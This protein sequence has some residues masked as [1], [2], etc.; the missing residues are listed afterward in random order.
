MKKLYLM[1]ADGKSGQGVRYCLFL[2]DST[3]EELKK[4]A[5]GHYVK[6]FEY[7]SEILLGNNENDLRIYR[8][9]ENE[10]QVI[11]VHSKNVELIQGI[12]CYER[13]GRWYGWVNNQGIELGEKFEQPLSFWVSAKLGMTAL[14]YFILSKNKNAYILSF[15]MK[16]ILVQGRYIGK[17][18]ICDDYIFACREDG[19][20]DVYNAGVLH[21][22]NPDMHSVLRPYL[23]DKNNRIYFWDEDKTWWCRLAGDNCFVIAD[24]ALGAHCFNP[25][26]N[27]SYYIL[28]KVEGGAKTEI[29]R[30]KYE[31]SSDCLSFEIGGL[32]YSMNYDTRL[33]DFDNP[34]PTFKLKIKNLFKLLW[35][36]KK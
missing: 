27:R 10:L 3:L 12:I 8:I 7:S 31:L 17:H 25:K 2:W 11:P 35:R 29:R 30:G 36:F 15:A 23:K 13:E 28:Y 9:Y 1:T 18:C 20:F 26:T 16:S 19:C 4:I 6:K 14:S 21:V 32:I 5:D 22:Y 24:N 34:Q 33:V